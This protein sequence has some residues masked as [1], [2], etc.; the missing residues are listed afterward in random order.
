[1]FNELLVDINISELNKS[2]IDF[3]VKNL[4]EQEKIINNFKSY[5]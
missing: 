3:D 2:F 5:F 1:M 4:G